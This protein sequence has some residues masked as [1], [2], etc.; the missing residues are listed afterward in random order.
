ME[1][2]KTREE[3]LEQQLQNTKAIAQMALQIQRD[4]NFLDNLAQLLAVAHADGVSVEMFMKV[5]YVKPVEWLGQQQ[6][7]LLKLIEQAGKLNQ[8]LSSK[9]T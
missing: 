1:D 5:S 7:A 8:V 2:T 6:D 9:Q 3:M 4:K